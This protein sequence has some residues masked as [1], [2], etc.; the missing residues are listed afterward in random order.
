MQPTSREVPQQFSLIA[1]QYSNEE[2][3]PC[4][5]L[6]GDVSVAHLVKDQL[7]FLAVLGDDCNAYAPLQ[8][9][10]RLAIVFS[11]YGGCTV[12]NISDNYFVLY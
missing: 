6:V 8:F 2:D 10:Q 7:T 9:L 11:L 12:E 4:V 5:M 1:S 3:V